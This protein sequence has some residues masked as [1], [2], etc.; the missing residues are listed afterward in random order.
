M[1]QLLSNLDIAVN[2]ELPY[3]FHTK[4]EMVAHCANRPFMEQPVAETMSCSHP[5][6]TRFTM[7][8]PTLH[9]GYCIPCLI[10]R[11][12][13]SSSLSN[14]PTPYAVTDLAQPLF[15]KRRS[16]LRAL[17]MALDRF[18]KRPPRPSDLLASGPLRC[19]DKELFE[20]LGV[21]SRGLDEV[22]TFLNKYPPK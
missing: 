17:R 10:R 5:S 3:R 19:P 7:K 20:Y 13:L 18:A 9:C 2:L 21:F 16:D 8:D 14:D 12:A 11:A 4:G 6:A 15:G 1:R 22:R